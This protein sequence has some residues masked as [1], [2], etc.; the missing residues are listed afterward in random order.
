[1]PKILAAA[2]LLPAL[3]LSSAAY[4][5]CV[6]DHMQSCYALERARSSFGR[7]GLSAS[8]F[9]A[10]EAVVTCQGSHTSPVGSGAGRGGVQAAEVDRALDYL[11]RRKAQDPARAD[12]DFRA[13]SVPGQDVGAT[14][15]CMMQRERDW[16]AVQF[17]NTAPAAAPAAPKAADPSGKETDGMTTIAVEGGKLRIVAG[18]PHGTK[19]SIRHNDNLVRE[20]DGVYLSIRAVIVLDFGADTVLV[21]STN[22]GGSGTVDEYGLVS[23]GPKGRIY[24]TEL[25]VGSGR[26]EYQVAG[27]RISFELGLDQG[28]EVRAV[29]T[30]SRLGVTRSAAPK[31]GLKAEDCD[32]LYNGVL[33]ECADARQTVCRYDDM[34]ISMASQRPVNMM[35]AD[36]PN[37]RRQDFEAICEQSCRTKRKLTFVAFRKAVCQP[38]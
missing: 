22:P 34:A 32:F 21:Y 15:N 20:F 13:C 37:F 10:A 16:A 19:S 26:F 33:A 5:D 31:T 27:D 28:R 23:I 35:T 3:V 25:P 4:A 18:D 7:G 38:K 11:T 12:A 30:N 14:L 8:E 6:R 36:N 17:R 24:E 9:C 1:M 29:Y 2:C